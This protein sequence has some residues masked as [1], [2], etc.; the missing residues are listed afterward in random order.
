MY[1]ALIG[2]LAVII[3]IITNHDILFKRHNDHIIRSYRFFL[4]AVTFYYITD[5]L[6]GILD[7]YR[8]RIPLYVDT[9]IY[10]IAMAAGI[11]ALTQ[12][13]VTYIE[14]KTIF[15]KILPGAGIIFFVTI[16]ILMIINIFKPILFSLNGAG[17]YETATGRYWILGIQTILL[18]VTAVYSFVGAIRT[19]GLEGRRYLTVG[20]LAVSM[21][22]AIAIQMFNPL[23]PLYSIGY[24]VGT[25]LL[26]V[27]V[28]ENEKEE[29]REN[30]EKTL[31]HEK[32]QSKELKEAWELAYT[33]ALT[34]VESRLAYLEAQERIDN[35]I[36]ENQLKDFALIVFDI[37][38][39]KK[40]NDTL[41]HQEGDRYIISACELIKNTFRNSK[42]YRIGGDE[43]MALLSEDDFEVKD[44]LVSIFKKKIES[45]IKKNE[46][47]MAFGMAEYIQG[48]DYSFRHMFERAD[49]AMYDQKKQIKSAAKNS[50]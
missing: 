12:Y 21:L 23:L 3:L 41:G 13:V 15:R 24:L 9:E 7:Y 38:N 26:R 2:T 36:N 46:V 11:M 22:T 10:F 19:K 30:L 6:W 5:I 47:V 49:F 37:N 32:E 29:Y 48:E 17:D 40:V 18:F 33:D 20:L 45:N 8:Y 31:A 1:Y 14:D 4:Y 44:E 16:I 25:C 27:F 35:L 39:L 34:G 43:F 28:I 50:K 42:V